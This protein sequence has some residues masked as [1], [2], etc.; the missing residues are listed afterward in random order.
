MEPEEETV[1]KIVTEIPKEVRIKWQRIIDIIAKV[2]LVPAGLIM[3]VDSKQIEVF[4]KSTTKENPY[5]EGEKADLNTGLYC[6]TVIKNSNLL[7]VANAMND[8]AWNHNPDIKLG[9]IF[10]LG[11]PLQWPDGKIFGTICVLDR[12]E[13]QQAITY[14]ELIAE[15]KEVINGDLLLI[16]EIEKRKQIEQQLKEQKKEYEIFNQSLINRE[17][18]IIE[19]KEEINDLCEK[20][21]V[22]PKYPPIWQSK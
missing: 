17:M 7:L 22:A 1:K 19:L 2:L 21:K 9:M 4:I 3:K 5:E 15:F 12:K 8:P 11:Y 20:L 14:K 10:Y 16:Y 18:R 6:E 13:N